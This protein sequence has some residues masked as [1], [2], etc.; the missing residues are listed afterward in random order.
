MKTI[1]RFVSQLMTNRIR[2]ASCADIMGDKSS[3]M[4]DANKV[5]WRNLN[6][7]N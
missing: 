6:G 7:T 3:G 4:R 1:R 2:H 5:D